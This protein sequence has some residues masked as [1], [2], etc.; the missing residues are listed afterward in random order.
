MMPDVPPEVV[1]TWEWLQSGECARWFLRYRFHRD[2][3]VLVEHEHLDAASDRVFLRGKFMLSLPLKGRGR[4]S[5][6]LVL[7]LDPEGNLFGLPTPV[8][9]ELAADEWLGPDVLKRYL[10]VA[11]VLGQTSDLFR[12]PGSSS[13]PSWIFG[14]APAP[15]SEVDSSPTQPPFLRGVNFPWL[16]CVSEAHPLAASDV[17]YDLQLIVK[18]ARGKK[19]SLARATSA[20]LSDA[21]PAD[22][23]VAS[24]GY[25]SSLPGDPAKA[26]QVPC[27]FLRAPGSEPSGTVFRLNVVWHYVFIAWFRERLVSARSGPSTWLPWERECANLPDDE[28]T[29]KSA[30]GKVSSFLP[31]PLASSDI[32]SRY[33][34]LIFTFCPFHS[35][36]GATAY[37]PS[38]V[39]CSFLATPGPASSIVAARL[40]PLL[41]SSILG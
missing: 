25:F 33:G 20:P 14:Y 21:L 8:P 39:R 3:S 9:P 19:A 22:L 41:R 29:T 10:S 36:T 30:S 38:S 34:F 7:S 28:V 12:I 27:I 4:S 15:G 6:R 2:F 24:V 18:G 5:F 37:T 31:R 32:L 35:T 23:P 17:V 13:I 11:G 26:H 40:I 16:P 1:V